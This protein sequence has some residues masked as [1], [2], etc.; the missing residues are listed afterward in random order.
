[1]GRVPL[2]FPGWHLAR[3]VHLSKVK[4]G[5]RWHEAYTVETNHPVGLAEYLGQ[6]GY[7]DRRAAVAALKA[8]LTNGMNVPTSS[9]ALTMLAAPKE[10]TP[11][12]PRTAD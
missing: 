11:A 6:L 12:T 9:G 8:Q 4:A 7:Q 5:A 2:L 1:V 10:S 3:L